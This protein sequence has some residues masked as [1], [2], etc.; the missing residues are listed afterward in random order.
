MKWWLND[1]Q[2][3]AMRY[4]GLVTELAANEVFVFGS[5]HAGR[6]GKGAAAQACKWGA[7]NGQGSGLM[8]RTYGIPT[9]G[10]DLSRALPIREIRSE[11]DVFI[12][13]AAAN[14]ELTFLVTEVGCGLAGYDARD[15]AP[16][17]RPCL[18]LSNV[19][20]PEGFHRALAHST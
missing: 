14:P 18:K 15:I 2:D 19:V 20:L 5:N 6:H 8:G 12:A 13:F 7:K 9:K 4:T 11:V 16:L 17:F 1:K 10:Y 3:H